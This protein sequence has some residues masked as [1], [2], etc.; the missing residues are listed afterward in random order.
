M[1]RM[2]NVERAIAGADF[3]E[4]WYKYN[5]VA[6]KIYLENKTT[7]LINWARWNLQVFSKI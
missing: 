6:G 5:K 7:F 4:G 1:S 3:T 2:N